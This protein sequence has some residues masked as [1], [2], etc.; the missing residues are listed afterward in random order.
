MEPLCDHLLMCRKNEDGTEEDVGTLRWCVL[1]NSLAFPARGRPKPAF[2]F[3]PR[4]KLGRVAIVKQLRGTGAGRI[5][6][7]ALEEHVRER[8]GRA[9]DVTRGKSSLELLAYS[10][11]TAEGFYAKMGWHSIG[12]DFLEVRSRM[13]SDRHER[14]SERRNVTGGSTA[15]Q[16]GQAD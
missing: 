2:R 3:P 4:S 14:C 10:Q 11:K 7:E 15:R 8:R 6:C 12:P 9:A 1:S 16:N 5:L 13:R